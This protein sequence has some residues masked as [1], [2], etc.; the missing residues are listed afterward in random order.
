MAEEALTS[1]LILEDR[2]SATLESMADG[3]AKAEDALDGLLE[4]MKSVDAMGG[5]AVHAAADTGNVDAQMAALESEL[6]QLAQMDALE[7]ELKKIAELGVSAPEAAKIEDTVN[8]IMDAQERSEAAWEEML[9]EIEG[10]AENILGEWED[11]EHGTARMPEEAAQE[12]QR[13]GQKMRQRVRGL[14]ADIAGWWSIIKDI[15]NKVTEAFGKIAEEAD[16][17][18]MKMA[19]YG[20]VADSEGK[21]G[22]ERDKRS[23]EIYTRQQKLAQALGVN[24]EAFNETVLNMYSNGAG[25]VKSIEEA[26]AIAASSYMAMDV[27]GLRGAKKDQVMGEVQ[28]MVSVGIADPDQ[29]QEAMKIA[30]NILRTIEKQW[31]KNQKGKPF[32]LN[33]GEMITDATGKIAQLAQNGQITADLV[34]QAMVNS[35]QEVKEKW[36]TLPNTWERL[37]NRVKIITERIVNVILEDIERIADDPQIADFVMAA[38]KLL[39]KLVNFIRNYVMPVVGFILRTVGSVLTSIMDTLNNLF[40]TT[41]TAIPTLIAIGALCVAWAAKA[42]LVTAAINGIKAA[43]AW[44]KANKFLALQFAALAAALAIAHLV[45]TTQ[46]GQEI[47]LG[48]TAAVAYGF[49]Q[50]GAVLTNLVGIGKWVMSRLTM[51]FQAFAMGAIKGLEWV[52]EKMAVVSDMAQEALEAIRAKE[53]DLQKDM[54]MTADWGDSQLEDML[55]QMDENTRYFKEYNKQIPELA[56]ANLAKNKDQLELKGYLDGILGELENAPGKPNNPATV[57]GK[58]AIDGEYADIIRRAAGVEI[59]NRYTTLRP[60]VNATFGDIHKMDADDV[61]G[62]LGQSI[63]DAEAAAI[64]DAQALGA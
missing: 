49:Q 57:K 54:E 51:V 53:A 7:N 13:Q 59:V 8:D 29:I 42:G 4:A 35:V 36:E 58:V 14:G 5:I 30:P 27:A 34:A 21:T 40:E 1:T 39:Q 3:A 10:E 37:T 23:G 11:L 19:R 47:M 46:E 18:G 48:G 50:V 61:L 43:L 20:L 63:Q 44:I 15:F 22:S 24:S 62:R 52:L 28:S 56:A 55:N 16:K 64:S 60:T 6:K 17:F 26:Q 31:E 25:V 2:A 32:R 12:A 38:M 45:R 41:E 9:A 33:N